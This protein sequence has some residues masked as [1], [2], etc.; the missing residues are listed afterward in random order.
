[1]PA[2]FSPA[3]RSILN[4]LVIPLGLFAAWFGIMRYIFGSSGEGT[5]SFPRFVHVLYLGIIGI[6]LWFPLGY[7]DFVVREILASIFQQHISL[8]IL[9]R[10][11]LTA[12]LLVWVYSMHKIYIFTKREQQG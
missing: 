9:S 4:Y 12:T 5:S 7:F 11:S 10:I 3:I 1:M 6:V 2:G 8:G